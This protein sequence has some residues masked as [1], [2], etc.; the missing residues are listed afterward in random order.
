LASPPAIG[1]TTAAAGTF[2]TLGGTTITASTMFSGPHNGTV[3]ATTPNTGLFTSLGASGNLTLSGSAARILGDFSNATSFNKVS[4]QSSTVNGKTAV[5]AIPNGTSRISAYTVIDKDDSANYGYGSIGI[6][7]AAPSFQ[8]STGKTGTGVASDISIS[9]NETL[10]WKFATT[11]VL[12]QPLNTINTAGSFMTARAIMNQQWSYAMFIEPTFTSYGASGESYGMLLRC[13]TEAGSYTIPQIIALG[14]GDYTKGAGSTVSNFLAINVGAL[15]M[16]SVSNIG[17]ASTVPSSSAGSWNFYASGTAS[18]YFAGTTGI[19]VSPTSRNNTV[20]QISNGIGFPATQVASS[21]ANT[22]DDYE[23]GTWTP[24]V[25]PET[26]TI[27]TYTA[28]GTY[29]KI[30]RVVHC[31]VSINITAWG[32]AGG[33]MTVGGFPF[34]CN[35]T[36]G[37]SSAYRRGLDGILNNVAM[38]AAAT[39]T[40]SWSYSNGSAFGGGNGLHVFSLTYHT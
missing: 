29:T 27:T 23:E 20:L 39:Y 9:P 17:I 31:Q 13:A 40:S 28:T 37:A 19:G 10:Q 33:A 11:G 4:F 6:D 3:G 18:N 35:G 2:T 1:G 38:A 34:T 24:T 5:M 32:S 30:G 22:L 16:G 12:T 26:G 36:Y 21:D 7:G 25:T 8:I 15:T 14:V